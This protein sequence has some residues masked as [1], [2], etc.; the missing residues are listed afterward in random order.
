[1]EPDLTIVTACDAD[2]FWG[3]FLLVA[4]LRLTGILS[5]I[6]VLE[7]GFSEAEKELLAQFG[8]LTILPLPAGN[9]RNLCTRKAEALLG[10]ESEW[11][12]W[13]DSDCV[14]IGDLRPL[15]IPPNGAFQI[16]IRSE[17][18]TNSIYRRYYEPEDKPGQIPKRILNQW[19]DDVGDLKE[20]RFLG[21]CVTNVLVIHRRFRSFIE[22]WNEQIL[23]VIPPVREGIT[24]RS[25]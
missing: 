9:R 2:Y 16:R 21:S 20:P 7:E 17:A 1:M 10:A 11:I 14:S 24:R 19:R 4:S 22:R 5:P 25:D 8:G 13:L 3:A 23:K 12:A 15:L 6:H 18:E